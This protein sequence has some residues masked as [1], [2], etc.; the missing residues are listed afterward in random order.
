MFR[1]YASSSREF[2]QTTNP[3][4]EEVLKVAD[5]HRI[6]D[7]E[8][9]YDDEVEDDDGNDNNDNV[10]ETEK[11]MKKKRSKK[12]E[13]KKKEK[14]KSKEVKKEKRREKEDFF[15]ESFLST[16]T[17]CAA[18]TLDRRADYELIITGPFRG[19]IPV[20][21][22]QN[23]NETVSSNTLA[24]RLYKSTLSRDF[25]FDKDIRAVPKRRY[26]ASKA[27]VDANVPRLRRLKRSTGGYQCAG[28]SS[29]VFLPVTV[30][31]SIEHEFEEFIK[32][33]QLSSR[34]QTL[35]LTDEQEAEE[36]R[37][38]F[39]RKW[40]PKRDD[41]FDSLHWLHFAA[42]QQLL[43][44]SQ[45]KSGGSSSTREKLQLV[46]VQKLKVRPVWCICKRLLHFDYS[47]L[48]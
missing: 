18:W 41:S 46:A 9:N 1:A 15:T 11:D 29:S 47:K 34:D 10:V 44:R 4:T 22:V 48:S 32:G 33:V 12:E 39:L 42:I 31:N 13:R 6:R 20:Y 2:P 21:D 45:P 40:K 26:F 7:D 17:S 23:G 14:K 5:G 19:S 16:T 38:V 25:S 30:Y 8:S 27:D 24:M 37:L 35:F 36:W 3:A 28:T 43:V